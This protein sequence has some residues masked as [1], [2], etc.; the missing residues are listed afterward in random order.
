M[1]HFTLHSSKMSALYF[2]TLPHSQHTDWKI[3][4]FWSPNL[5]VHYF[6]TF[7]LI[8]KAK[9]SYGRRCRTCSQQF[10]VYREIYWRLQKRHTSSPTTCQEGSGLILKTKGRIF[11]LLFFVEI[12]RKS[13]TYINKDMICNSKCITAASAASKLGLTP[14]LS[15]AY[16]CN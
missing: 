12:C 5:M 11:F 14:C 16:A 4:N 6:R 3:S 9:L 10:T 13:P 1:V 15:W 7:L 2:S 8:V